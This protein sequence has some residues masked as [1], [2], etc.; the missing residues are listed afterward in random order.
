MSDASLTLGGELKEQKGP[1]DR[2]LSLFTTVHGGEGISAL[3]LA[4][5][6]F[7][8][9]GA[10]YVL[11]TVRE[12]LI[13]GQP[14]GAELKSY[15]SA[16]QALLF[17]IVAPLYSALASK[18]NRVKLIGGVTAFFIS[19]LVLF[20]M[21]GGAGVKIGIAYF[22]WVGIFNM[23]A[24]AQFWAFANDI[25]T[26]EQGKRLFPLVGV[27]AS[28][29]AWVGS[30]FAGNVY[31]AMGPYQLMLTSA[32]IL[33]LCILLTITVH[34]RESGKAT[35][36]RKREVEKPLDKSGAFQLL[37]RHR[38]LLLIA[39]VVLLMNTVNTTGEFILS[40]FVTQ[41]AETLP[42]ADRDAF[43]GEFYG[44]YFSLVNLVGF[45]IQTFLVSRLFKWIGVGGGL[46]VLP[47]IALFGYGSLLFFPILS[48]VR[49]AKIV[50]NATDYSL[51][52]TVRHALYLPTSREAK[53]KVKAVTDTFFVR[54]G[55]LIQAGLVF[56]GTALA[57][58]VE[59]FAIL[60]VALVGI[61][62]VIALMVYREHKK[63]TAEA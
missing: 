13:L 14:G 27:G 47:A 62:L 11:K 19:N 20:A 4:A 17:L 45:L 36:E 63:L 16:G 35:A 56:V 58:T 32:V 24:V 53:Y 1:L 12:P 23:L 60:N 6:V 31:R 7:L 28:L 40:K 57:F 41:S 8:L 34:R 22:L 44:N 39:F 61:W 37:F 9:L 51:N 55:D 15:S 42:E 29:G 33:G 18:V 48:I 10:Y 46:F 25:Y 38:Y 49:S 54:F 59:K 50:E 43:L 26:E 52:N 21:L 3:L 5:N 30:T 2:I